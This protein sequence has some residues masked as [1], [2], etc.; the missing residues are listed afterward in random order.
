MTVLAD[1]PYQLPDDPDL[2]YGRGELTAIMPPA[3]VAQAVGAW[4]PFPRVDDRDDWVGIPERVRDE[5]LPRAEKALHAE[6]PAL[7]ASVFADFQRNGDRSRFELPHFARR[8]LLRDL[9]IGAGL[10]GENGFTD[11]VLDAVWSICEES[12]WGVPAHSF[13]RR[14]QELPLPAVDE[15]VIDLFAAETGAQV[16]WTRYLMG[17]RLVEAGGQ[18]FDERILAELER[19]LLSPLLE[20]DDW[21]WLSKDRRGPNNWNPWICSNLLVVILLTQPAGDRRTAMISKLIAGLDAYVDQ[22]SPDGGC[23]EGQSYWAVGPAKLLDCLEALH[24][25]SGGRLNG[26]TLPKV[27]A[28]AD[29]PVAMHVSGR[30]MVQHADGHGEWLVEASVLHRAGRLLD[31]AGARQL[32]LHLRDLPSA[33]PE[34]ARTNLWRGLSEVFEPGYADGPPTPPPLPR[35]T[36]FPDLQVLTAREVT[37][38]I[39]GFLL[40]IK[41]GHN[42]EHHNHNDVGALSVALDGE[43]LVVDPAVGVYTRTTF[44]PQ[45]YD[46]FELNSDWHSLPIVDGTVQSPGREFCGS[47]VSCTDHDGGVTMSAEL[48]GAWPRG[49]MRSYRR[50]ASLDREGHRVVVVDRW[51]TDGVASLTLP[52]TLA[53]EPQVDGSMVTLPSGRGDCLLE[54]DGAASIEVEVRELTDDN[55]VGLWGGHLWRLLITPATI[56]AGELRLTFSRAR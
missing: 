46:L 42:A 21:F 25:A 56:D 35:Q 6:W 52:L 40:A 18:A 33:R 23:S 45:R 13:S 31:H 12:F 16:A 28:L 5:W 50:S 44:G 9:V 54:I 32:A 43:H 39:D 53:V 55:L 11:P 30:S 49:G 8:G 29:Y 19:R 34:R 38:S 7:P 14:H 24:G 22:L 47:D 27:A 15:P 1:R 26:F 3:L 41:A 4:H 20:R 17:D 2:P 10:T 48:A 37:G 36:W 51:R